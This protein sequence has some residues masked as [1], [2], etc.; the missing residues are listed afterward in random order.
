MASN[1]GWRWRFMGFQSIEEG[2]VVQAW[3]NSLPVEAREEI[4]DLFQRLQV[5]T[6]RRWRRPEFDPLEGAGGISEIR[7]NDIR[8]EAGSSTYRIYGFFGPNKT[9][10][11]LLH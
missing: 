3:F 6:D 8:S 10:Y 1:Q 11:T 7:P 9:D 4:T 2:R 5:V